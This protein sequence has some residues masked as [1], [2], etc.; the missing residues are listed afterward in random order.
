M[1]VISLLLVIFALTGCASTLQGN[2]KNDY[3][4]GKRLESIDTFRDKQDLETYGTY[5]QRYDACLNE[6]GSLFTGLRGE[7]CTKHVSKYNRYEI[8]NP[9]KKMI[10]E[11][12]ERTGRARN[13]AHAE[14]VARLRAKGYNVCEDKSGSVFAIP[15]LCDN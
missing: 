10:A 3:N 12:R 14:E 13:S 15:R 9:S 1:N 7:Y 6:A 11:I 8:D 4:G 2:L 5:K